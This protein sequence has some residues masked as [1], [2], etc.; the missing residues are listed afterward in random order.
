MDPTVEDSHREQL[1]VDDESCIIEVLDTSGD[2][3]Y[4]D[5]IP[6]WIGN[7]NGFLLVYSIGSRDSFARISELV[8]LVRQVA[9][10]G[11]IVLVGNKRDDATVQ[12]VELGEGHNVATK[13]DCGFFETSARTGLNVEAAFSDLV[14][15]LRGA[16]IKEVTLAAEIE[17][18]VLAADSAGWGGHNWPVALWDR[19]LACLRRCCSPRKLTAG[20]L[21]KT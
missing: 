6:G 13:N 15:R 20:C 10:N 7:N 16:T 4:A 11:P 3:C 14:R 12:L 19:A 8:K 17:E 1:T 9:P 5:L 2:Y 18:V 21:R